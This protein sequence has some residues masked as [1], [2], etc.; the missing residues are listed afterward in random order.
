LATNSIGSGTASDPLT[1]TTDDVPQSMT[2]VTCSSVTS[3]AMTLTWTALATNLNGGDAVVF[4]G[5]E[6]SV[7]G[8]AYA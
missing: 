8:S 2:A 1:F 6:Y 5:V 4:Y 3:T 7:S